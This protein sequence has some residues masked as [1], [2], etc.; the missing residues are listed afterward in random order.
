MKISKIEWRPVSCRLKKP[1]K[2]ALR[3]L[4]HLNSF[5]L[6]LTD[7]EGQ[8]GIGACSA[9]AAITG[10]TEGS[11]TAA[12]KIIS[13]ALKGEEWS[14]LEPALSLT[15]EALKGNHSAKAA[16]DIALHDLFC[17][18]LNIP[19]Y[20]F[21][22]GARQSLTTDITISLNSPE[23]MAR[24]TENA[25]SQG[26]TSLKIKV[27]NREDDDI[28]RLKAVRQAA[29]KVSKLRIDANQGWTPKEA[30]RI[31]NEMERLKLN[32][33]LVEQPVAAGDLKGMRYVRRNTTLPVIADESVFNARDALRIA[34]EGAADGINIKLMKSGGI[35]EAR[36]IAAVAEAAGL[37]IMVGSMMESHTGVTAAAHFAAS[38]ASLQEVDLDVPLLCGEKVE[39]GGVL[40]QNSRIVLPDDR[41]LG[42]G[43]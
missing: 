7:Q 27:G 13:D 30:V 37:S 15:A 19:L 11:L 36:R 28:A 16:F 32:L 3:T 4:E 10:E 35:G 2:T 9:T 33:E 14:G 12:F 43:A 31:L 40:Y 22:G 42:I 39:S 18:S 24:D 23:E 20:R 38:L 5:Q 1:F 17:K 34:E 21:L 29:G 6:I 25:V 41:G 26:F 8:T